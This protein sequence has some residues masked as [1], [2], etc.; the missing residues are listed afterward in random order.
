MYARSMNY[1][2]V[3]GW[4]YDLKQE[5]FK[6]VYME[7]YFK[8][9]SQINP[10]NVD[11]D[12]DWPGIFHLCLKISE[13]IFCALLLYKDIFWFWWGYTYLAWLYFNKNSNG[14]KWS[15]LSGEFS[16]KRVLVYFDNSA[17]GYFIMLRIE[18]DGKKL[19]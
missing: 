8:K 1:F 6:L 3:S 11:Q 14:R 10:L 2:S 16:I 9:K 5:K 19:I 18:L 15:E 4:R 12:A 7:K 17:I 13:F